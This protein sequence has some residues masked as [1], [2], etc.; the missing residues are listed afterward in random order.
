MYSGDYFNLTFNRSGTEP[1]QPVAVNLPNRSGLLA[2]D[3]G[4]LPGSEAHTLHG[5]LKSRGTVPPIAG[6]A[7]HP[8]Y[9]NATLTRNE[10]LDFLR[11]GPPCPKG[12]A[13][14]CPR[15]FISYD[16]LPLN[17]DNLT[18]RWRTKKTRKWWTHRMA[19]PGVRARGF[20]KRAEI[21]DR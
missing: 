6:K 7:D 13:P 20:G 1:K 2:M 18:A 16:L 8:R 9:Q 3:K 5:E 10:P 11:G 4:R 17:P 12:L 19:K 15:G 14:L 21:E